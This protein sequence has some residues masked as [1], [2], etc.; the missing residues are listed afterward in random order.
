MKVIINGQP[1]TVD[2]QASI[3]SLLEHLG[4]PARQ[5]AVELN[6]R[7]VPRSDHGAQALHEG[8]HLEV[9]TLVGGG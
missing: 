1:R 9:V 4:L 2:D 5:V 3:A 6:R 8:D 7:L